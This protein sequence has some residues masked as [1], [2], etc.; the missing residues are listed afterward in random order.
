MLPNYNFSK[1]YWFGSKYIRTRIH[2]PLGL[3]THLYSILWVIIQ[4][5]QPITVQKWSTPCWLWGKSTK[6]IPYLW[7]FLK[8]SE[9]LQFRLAILRG[10]LEIKLFFYIKELILGFNSLLFGRNKY[11]NISIIKCFF[12]DNSKLVLKHLQV[13][14]SVL[15]PAKFSVYCGRSKVY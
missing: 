9:F 12:I 15:K 4:L 6:Y 10:F 11:L 13:S 2:L 8:S 1:I 14:P 3:Q 7:R 5:Y